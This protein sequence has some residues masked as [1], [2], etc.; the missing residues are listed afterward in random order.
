METSTAVRATPLSWAWLGPRQ[1][2]SIVQSRATA[3]MH[4]TE[5]VTYRGLSCPA[6]PGS[7]GSS[8]SVQMV[9]P[10]TVYRLPQRLVSCATR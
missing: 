8:C 7:G 10:D 6:P 4:E 5:V 1:V 2:H 3:R 9:F